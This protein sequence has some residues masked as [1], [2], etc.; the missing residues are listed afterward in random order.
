MPL[1]QKY[2]P[3]STYF[4]VDFIVT[5]NVAAARTLTVTARAARSL[6]T[7]Q[8]TIQKAADYFN[9]KSA[10]IAGPATRGFIFTIETGLT[11]FEMS[12]LDVV[13]SVD[14]KDPAEGEFKADL[15]A[16]V[17][18]IN[19]NSSLVTA[20][21]DDGATGVPDN[22]SSPLFLSGGSEGTSNF[23]QFQNALNLLKQVRV[24]TIVV[25]TGDPA[26]HAAVDAHCAYMGGIGRSERDGIVGILNAGLTDVPSKTE[27]KEQVVD[28]NSRHI[29]AVGQA[30]ER[31]D[32]LGEKT[33]FLPPFYA[34]V[35]AGMQAGAPVGTPLTFKYANVLSLR[36][37]SSW[38]PTDDAEEMIQAGCLI[39][40]E[41][42]GVG[43]RIVRNITT[44]LS[45]NNLAFIEGS[46]NQAVNQ[47]V[48]EFR[49]SLEV[50]VGK[51]GFAGTV[52]ATRGVARNKLG[53][54][55]AAGIITAYRSLDLEL[56]ADVMDVG[57]EMAPV[58]PVNF[59]RTNV[60]LV[61]L[62]QLAAAQAA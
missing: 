49:T 12:N 35:V 9:A 57:V 10:V 19:Q 23:T 62:A 15:Y 37:H 52:S 50:A 54:L 44:H 55:V 1:F 8:K 36:Q 59:V 13:S 5:G 16:I 39:G 43:R 31:Y 34:A 58:I 46:V 30:I 22:T 3:E 6:A 4:F 51:K 41:I 38:N 26:V 20:E 2:S 45:S 40:R 11:T 53:L 7:V 14:V 60:H 17:A 25:L 47:A 56:L 42:E 32:T 21:V 24:N 27:F 29:R 48:F 33:E 61:T 28:L 18:W